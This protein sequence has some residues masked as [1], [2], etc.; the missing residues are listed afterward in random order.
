[1]RLSLVQ[2]TLEA[3]YAWML[4]NLAI[5]LYMATH[6]LMQRIWRTWRRRRMMQSAQLAPVVVIWPR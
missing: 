4:L 6:F 5:V 2:I 3:G 1:M